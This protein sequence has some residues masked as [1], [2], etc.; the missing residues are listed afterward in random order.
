MSEQCKWLHE[1]LE[2]LPIIKFPFE[3]RDLPE[4]GIYFFYEEGE[5]WGHGGSLPRIVKVGTCTG[6][7]NFRSRLGQHYLLNEAV[8]D[9]DA[10]KPRPHDRSVLRKHIGMAL[11]N[12]NEGDYFQVWSENLTKR[13]KREQYKHR[14][15]IEK[16]KRFESAVTK[17][18][19]ERFSFRF[20]VL[21]D[22]KKERLGLEKH[23]IGTI[24]RCSLCKP[25]PDSD[26]LGNHSPDERIRASG[27]WLIQHFK[28][29][30]L[31]DRDRETVSEA[32]KRTQRWIESH[33]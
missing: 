13:E 20:I 28:A 23:L 2:Q 12:R 6:S 7:N 21:E 17:L 14:R 4:N 11:L 26:W 33:R 31:S 1:Q 22:N 8:M 19:R 29:S 32:I 25:E 18:I 10:T 15:D 5:E 27:L 3:L 16:E 9:F 30:P 24:S